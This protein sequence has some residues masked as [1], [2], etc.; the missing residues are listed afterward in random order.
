MG[1]RE[2]S[3]ETDMKDSKMVG[4]TD[5]GRGRQYCQCDTVMEGERKTQ[6]GVFISEQDKHHM[7]F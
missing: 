6:R 2:S 3:R 7:M 5:V 1:R 4:D